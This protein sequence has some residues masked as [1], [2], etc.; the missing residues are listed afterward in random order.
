MEAAQSFSDFERGKTVRIRR[1]TNFDEHNSRQKRYFEQSVKPTMVPADSPY[2]KRHINKLLSFANISAGERVLEAG[3]GMGRYTLILA[4]QGIKVE[5]MDI[6]PVLLDKMRTYAGVGFD[7]PLYCADVLQFPS[8]LEGRFDA[9]IGFFTLHHFHNLTKCFEAMTSLLKPGGR[10]VFLEPNPFNPLYYIQIL[11]TPGMTWQGDKG[12]LSMR[13]DL[14]FK[15]MKSAGLSRLTMTRFGFFP[16]FIAN[17]KW[18]QKFE[19]VLES[20]PLWSFLLPFQL[21]K[22][23]R[24]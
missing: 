13:P 6:S 20:I 14:I 3:C 10:I 18:G 15:A 22:G 8:E 5:G 23:E 11:I 2:L 17:L 4:R 24:R 12:I 21:F 16:P 9:V 1:Q 19:K 7:I